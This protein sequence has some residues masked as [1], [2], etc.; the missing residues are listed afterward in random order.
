M[1]SDRKPLP[2]IYK[3]LRLYDNVYFQKPQY[4]QD[5]HCPFCNKY[6]ESKRRVYCS[7]ECR[8]EYRNL[9]YWNRGRNTY[10]TQIL[11]RDNFTCQKCGTFHAYKNK[12]G[13]YL[14]TS[15]GH[16]DVHHIIYACNGGGDE[17]SNLITLC[18]NCHKKEHK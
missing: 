1:A 13:V 11:Y 7:D 9:V 3:V 17:P 4:I 2:S 18:D 14:P 15:D 5:K 10:S 12:Y 6:V 16:L 8:T